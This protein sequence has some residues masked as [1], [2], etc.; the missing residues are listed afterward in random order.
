MNKR[1][2]F[3]APLVFTCIAVL[4]GGS[5]SPG[6][7]S[8]E[9]PALPEAG[10]L[11]DVGT[12]TNST[13][14][15]SCPP[16]ATLIDT[17]RRRGA[18]EDVVDIELDGSLYRIYSQGA[19]ATPDGQLHR[20][21]DDPLALIPEAN[22]GLLPGGH[23]PSGVWYGTDPF[24]SRLF[25][26]QNAAPGRDATNP[27]SLQLE[28][29]EGGDVRIRRD[30]NTERFWYCVREADARDSDRDGD[31]LTTQ[32]ELMTYGTDPGLAD[33]DGDG[34]TDGEEV[35]AQTDPLVR[36]VPDAQIL[37]RLAAAS[38]NETSKLFDG[39]AVD[40]A[41]GLLF[42]R[43]VSIDPDDTM[44]HYYLSA[45]ETGYAPWHLVGATLERTDT[46]N[47]ITIRVTADSPTVICRTPLYLVPFAPALAFDDSVT[48]VEDDAGSQFIV[49]TKPPPFN[50][51]LR[52]DWSKRPATGPLSEEET[53]LT[54]LRE[55]DIAT[56]DALRYEGNEF[57]GQLVVTRPGVYT[58]PG[59]GGT[60]LLVV[61]DPLLT[62][63]NEHT[64]QSAT[65]TY[66][67]T[68]E[69]YRV[70]RPWPYD[71]A[72]H[73]TT[74]GD[75]SMQLGAECSCSATLSTGL[76]GNDRLSPEI[77]ITD[78]GE[79]ATG[80]IRLAGQIVW[81]STAVHRPA[82]RA[83]SRI[84]ASAR[85]LSTYGM[86]MSCSA[87]D[88]P[89]GNCGELEGVMLDSL[90]FRVPFGL[91]ASR[92]PTGFLSFSLDEPSWIT[93]ETFTRHENIANATHHYAV[94]LTDRA[95]VTGEPDVGVRIVITN[96]VQGVL[97]HTWDI[98]HVTNDIATVRFRKISRQNN[99][100]E[101]KTA[102]YDED[103]TWS[104]TDN[105]SGLV[106]TLR[107][108]DHLNDPGD[109]RLLEWREQRVGTNVLNR[110]TVES[111]LIGHR[112]HAVLREVSRR[113]EF[114][115]TT[116]DRSASYWDDPEHPLR[117]GNLR[118]LHGDDVDWEYREYDD[119]GRETTVYLQRNGS[120]LNDRR[121]AF[122][123]TYTYDPAHPSNRTISYARIDNDV[124]TDLGDLNSSFSVSGEPVEDE[125][126]FEGGMNL[127]DDKHRL[128]S[129]R[130]DD[131]S[132]TTNAYSCCRL[133]W[134]REDDGRVRLRSAITGEDRLYYAIEEAWQA[135]VSS[136]GTHN[137]TQYF[138]DALG[139]TTNVTCY[140]ATELGEATN[141]CASVG[142]EILSRTE[143]FYPEGGDDFF[144]VR[145]MNGR[146]TE[147]RITRTASE[148]VKEIRIYSSPEATEPDSVS[149]KVTPRG[150]DYDPDDSSDRWADP[151]DRPGDTEPEG[152]SPR[153][154][155]PDEEALRGIPLLPTIFRK[156]G[157]PVATALMTRWLNGR[158]TDEPQ[159][160]EACTNVVTMSWLCGYSPCR[161]RIIRILSDFRSKRDP[162]EINDYV[163]N[164]LLY[165]PP[166]I[167][168]LVNLPPVVLVHCEHFRA[169]SIDT[170]SLIS[171][172]G[173]SYINDLTA[174]L[175]RFAFYVQLGGTYK[176]G[177]I[178]ITRLGI[179]ARDTFEFNDAFWGLGF[180]YLGHWDF[181]NLE[182]PTGWIFDKML[183]NSDFRDY[184]DR[185]GYGQ[186]YYVYSDIKWFPLSR[187]RTYNFRE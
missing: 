105:I 186:D 99:I 43:T 137:V 47:A 152:R 173:E 89:E 117:H 174:S 52:L 72:C 119:L 51:P 12:R 34:L 5:K 120:S 68:S 97:E 69:T 36:S 76:E 88:C 22:D 11:V 79:S 118:E 65:V 138:M 156:N 91:D 131:G 13:W 48:E 111:R 149:R 32:E 135:D 157:W 4:W 23:T 10:T 128:I 130:Y 75:G 150:E 74:F 126:S 85:A 21:S 50:L 61:L 55:I 40:S 104:L 139:R 144:I 167:E 100:M 49:T 133:L 132:W 81:Q 112:Q 122:R 180:Q 16:D 143:T 30:D 172:R 136:N 62:Y 114:G 56:Q 124:V 83:W 25:T 184:R 87:D 92:R 63:G 15:A 106:E 90:K 6:T 37:A 3:L 162:Y 33:T 18:F 19:V 29:A 142:K 26:W 161:D 39:F 60:R 115:N 102:H 147:T 182:G 77:S 71:R 35:D 58:L 64:F 59:G 166:R 177:C 20:V 31:G 8:G 28:L 41:G 165:N 17:W 181:T 154:F 108:E 9:T 2:T 121:N 70:E 44:T 109:G 116:Y 179:Y 24:G 94:T 78:N 158:G 123:R 146:R 1:L 176:D 57:G 7:R 103:G 178:R 187:V 171:M 93:P 45:S 127:Y 54:P 183:F 101:D 98:A 160:V 159:S 148:T 96:T 164:R 46:T 169:F 73:W 27:V 134:W 80:E 95:S 129:T 125:S 14:S 153:L 82:G 86:C 141:R 168:H 42:A 53:A 140:V 151:D 38:T 145:E 155:G 84:S 163:L 185:T 110:T 113:V 66:D 175:G 67:I 107:R 170:Y